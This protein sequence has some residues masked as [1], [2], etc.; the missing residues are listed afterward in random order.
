MAGRT[1]N[2]GGCREQKWVVALLEFTLQG[3]LEILKS[4]MKKKELPK[5]ILKIFNI[6]RTLGKILKYSK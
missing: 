2:H 5:K 1:G 3:S 4:F 6:G